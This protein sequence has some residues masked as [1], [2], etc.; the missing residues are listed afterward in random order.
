MVLEIGLWLEE[1]G[2]IAVLEWTWCKLSPIRVTDGLWTVCDCEGMYL[3]E[4]DC[5]GL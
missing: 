4:M 2:P 3:I 5:E 1:I